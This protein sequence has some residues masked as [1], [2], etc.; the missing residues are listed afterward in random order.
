MISRRIICISGFQQGLARPT[1]LESI[2]MQLREIYS[3]R[4]SLPH[5]CVTLHRWNDNWRAFAN[6]I[7]RTGPINPGTMDIRVVAYSWGCGYAA[8]RFA[9]ALMK[10][11]LEVQRMVFSDPVYHSWFGLWRA[12]W[13]PLIGEPKIHIPQNVG[14]VSYVV[15]REDIPHGHELVA[16][17]PSRTQIDEPLA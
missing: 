3:C 4:D 9:K 2:W 17:N 15:Q 13:S 12:V 8:V 11:G 7:L 5:C 16:C 14:R 1:G 10:R 6:H